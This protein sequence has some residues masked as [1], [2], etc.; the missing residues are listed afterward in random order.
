MRNRLVLSNALAGIL[1]LCLSPVAAAEKNAVAGI[2][3][4]EV[5]H[6]ATQLVVDGAPFLIRG[7]EL[8]NSSAS[9]LAFM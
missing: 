9:S 3:R 2:P 4:L 8:E 1:A 7:G 6:G 5:R